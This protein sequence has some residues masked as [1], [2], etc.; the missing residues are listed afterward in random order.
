MYPVN[1]AAIL[2][3]SRSLLYIAFSKCKVSC[4]QFVDFN[5]LLLSYWKS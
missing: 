1:K 2:L 3:L 5:L 4:L